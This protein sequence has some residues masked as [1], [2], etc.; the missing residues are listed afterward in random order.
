MFRISALLYYYLSMPL[1][2]GPLLQFQC[3]FKDILQE[4]CKMTFLLPLICAHCANIQHTLKSLLKK[5][6][7]GKWMCYGQC[8]MEDALDWWS[9][10]M[11]IN[12]CRREQSWVN[13][14]SLSDY[15]RTDS[16]AEPVICL[17]AKCCGQYWLILSKK[18]SITPWYFNIITL[19]I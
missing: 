1:I 8:R 10:G 17:L 11:Q 18:E 5:K 9:R 7:K 3:Y 4:T 12:V 16:L 6:C 13:T 15:Q 14:H 2:T 19:I